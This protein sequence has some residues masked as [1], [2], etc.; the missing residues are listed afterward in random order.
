MASK[1]P[2]EL[3]EMYDKMKKL[4][5]A[6]KATIETAKVYVERAGKVMTVGS[7]ALNTADPDITIEDF[8]RIGAQV[9]S[10][11]DPTGVASVVAAYTYPKCTTAIK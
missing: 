7:I 11:V 5:D 1:A 6:N 3:I 9:A 10:L 8:V 2:K 4:Y